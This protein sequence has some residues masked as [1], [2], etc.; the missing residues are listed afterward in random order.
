MSSLTVRYIHEVPGVSYGN[1]MWPGRFPM[2]HG[3]FPQDHPAA[4][5]RRIFGGEIGDTGQMQAFRARGYWASCFPEGD[6]IT[7]KVERGQTPEQVAADIRAVFG[8][9]VRID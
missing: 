7:M 2:R 8:W 5:G 4:P 3:V 9:D 6:G 1:I